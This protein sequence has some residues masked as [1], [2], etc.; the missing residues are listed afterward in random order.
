MVTPF[1]ETGAVDDAAARRLARFLIENGS[2]GVVVAGSTGEAATLD[3][4][5]HIA[6]LRGRRRGG[7]RARRP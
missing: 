3:D 4:A 7:R 1:E 2:H 5:E 6:L